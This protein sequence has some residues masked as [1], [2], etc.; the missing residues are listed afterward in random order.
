MSLDAIAAELDPVKPMI[1]RRYIAAELC[2]SGN[3]LT[4]LNFPLPLH[5]FGRWNI[6]REFSFD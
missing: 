3:S 4:R 1:A 6:S 5:S 2:H